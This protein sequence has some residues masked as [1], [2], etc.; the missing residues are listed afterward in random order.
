MT[1]IVVAQKNQ[2]AVRSET[3]VMEVLVMEEKMN[4]KQGGT[5]MS[6]PEADNATPRYF[7]VPDPADPGKMTYWYLS[8]RHGLREWPP[9]MRTYGYWPTAGHPHR[10]R[11]AYRVA[12]LAA[13]E[14]DRNM[15]AA[16]FAKWTSRCCCCGRGLTEKQSKTF[17][18]GPYCRRGAP[19]AVLR[20]FV[21]RVRQLH[22]GL[23]A[24][25]DDRDVHQRVLDQGSQVPTGDTAVNGRDAPDHSQ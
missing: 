24:H 22:G 10:E 21:E 14:A 20:Q 6:A 11:A 12:V 9:T 5:A 4:V 18:I 2:S 7:A 16:R 8:S 3:E 13:I 15:C 1:A 19:P 23:E 25:R 17:G